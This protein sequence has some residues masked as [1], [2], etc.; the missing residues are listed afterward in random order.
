[1]SSTRAR[2]ERPS[3]PGRNIEL[4]PHEV[5]KSGSRAVKAGRDDGASPLPAGTV[6]PEP[7]FRILELAVYFLLA[8]IFTWP[9]ARHIASGIPM[10]TET[11][12]TVPLFNLWTLWWNADRLGA[13]YQGYWD[14]PIFYP[15]EGVFAFSEP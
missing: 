4:S 13:L 7:A 3:K 8:L 9:L 11:V 6:L 15:L 10:G 12:A 2:R 14:A 1:M 5:R